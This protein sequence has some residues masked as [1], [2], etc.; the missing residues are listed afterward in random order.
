M[1]DLLMKDNDTLI[2]KNSEV[3]NSDSGA[4]ELSFSFLSSQW[5]IVTFQSNWS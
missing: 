5:M 2:L 3:A 4:S 1:A